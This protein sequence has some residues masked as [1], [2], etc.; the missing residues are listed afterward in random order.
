MRTRSLVLQSLVLGT[1]ICAWMTSAALAETMTA[2]NDNRSGALQAS[3]GFG[4]P[5]KAGFSI[6]PGGDVA[7]VVALNSS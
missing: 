4:E 2:V 7:G 1:K 3:D 6:S 5:L